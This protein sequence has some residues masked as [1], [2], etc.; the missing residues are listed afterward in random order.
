MINILQTE[1]SAASDNLHYIL[2]HECG[3]VQRVCCRRLFVGMIFTA[4]FTVPIIA[5]MKAGGVLNHETIFTIVSFCAVMAA[6]AIIVTCCVCRRYVFRPT[7][8]PL[9]KMLLYFGKYDLDA[10]RH[11]VETGGRSSDDD[12]EA[13]ELPNASPNGPVLLCALF[14]DD[15]KMAFCRLM[16][17]EGFGYVPIGQ[18]RFYTDEDAE[19][20]R[21]SVRRAWRL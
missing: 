21:A 15:A 20:V 1:A 18:D 4:L 8:R 19:R 2:T 6:L 16:R 10:V 11:F 14:S 5:V 17:Y 13:P 7:G 9:T 3:C 12:V